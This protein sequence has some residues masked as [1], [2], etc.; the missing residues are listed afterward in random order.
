MLPSLA[1]ERRLLRDAAVILA[2]TLLVGTAANL[3]PGRR[4]PWWGQGRVAPTQGTDF[5]LIDPIAAEMLR[6]ALPGVLV[7]DTRSEAEMATGHIPG[8]ESFPYQ[9]AGTLLTTEA[10]ARLG[11]AD[12]VILVGASE[13]SDIEQLLAQELRLRGL[14]PPHIVLG[15]MPAWQ[16]SGLPL[17][18]AQP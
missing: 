18:G 6:S 15:G 10:L 13:E 3:I 9:D 16:A 2:A 5:N 11:K 12:A 8:A 7:L 14:A 1:V 4:L 17:D